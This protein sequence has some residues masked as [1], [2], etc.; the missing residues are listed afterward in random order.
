MPNIYQVI[1][2][3]DA[4]KYVILKIDKHKC[5]LKRGKQ[6]ITRFDMTN[7]YSNEIIDLDQFFQRLN[8]EA[9]INSIIQ[10]QL[11]PSEQIF[12]FVTIK[13]FKE[14]GNKILKNL[15]IA[16]LNKVTK[17][18]KNDKVQIKAILSKYHDDPSEGGHSGISRTLR[19]IKNYYYWPQMTKAISKYVKTCLKCQ[20]AK[21]TKHTK[22]PLTITET[23]ATAFDKVLIDT[24]GP[25][26]R[27]ENGNEYAVTIICDL[28]K[29]L[30]TVPI[31][32]KSAK[33]V[34]KAIF[35]NFILK[36]GPMK[37]IITDMG[38]EYKNQIIDDLC[39][40]M[41]IKNITSTAHHHQTLGTIERSHRTFNEYVRSYISVDK[42]DWDIWIQYF[43]YCFNTTPSVVHEYCPYELVFGRLPR[44]FIDFNRIDRIDPIYNMDDYSKEVKLRLEIAYRRAKNMLDKAKADRKIKY[45][46]NISNF[47][48]K[49]GDKILLKNET[50]HKLI[51]IILGPYLVSETGDNDN[52]T[53]IGNK[54]KKQIVH[55]D[56]LKI[57]NS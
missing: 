46:R 11:S 55:K 32:N 15:K 38:T 24:I 4:K 33:S 51:I 14:K 47:E 42:T 20:Q 26:P 56:R 16:L 27:S 10:T 2:N 40:Y 37:T 54:N 41:K 49:I 35:E 45:D 12:E 28:T 34:A 52:I 39:K 23:P 13:N 1:N 17:I 31:P 3:I 9:R 29:Y 8:E 36:Y 19:K 30:V 25:L 7:F 6:I 18:D 53:I 43:T 5:L 50:G 22:T 44:Q 57:F 21:T 48:L